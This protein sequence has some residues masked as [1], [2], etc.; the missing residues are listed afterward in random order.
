MFV[1]VA[2]STMNFV[3]PVILFIAVF[4]AAGIDTPSD[5][6]IIGKVFSDK[7]AAQAGLLQG[8]IVRT[9]DGQEISSWRQ[10]VN[11][12]QTNAGKSITINYERNGR[13][14]KTVVTPEFDPQGNRGIIGVVPVINN[15]HPGLFEAAGLAI[16][17]TYVVASAMLSGLGQMITGKAPADVAGP[18]GVA[19]MAGQVAQLGVLPLLQFAAFLSINLGLINLLPVPVLDGGHVV[20]LA[21][22]GIRGKPLNR[23]NL[24]F[25]QM[26]G[27]ALLMLLLVVAT[28]KDITRLR[29]F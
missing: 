11:A 16:K 19:Q 25:I 28:F 4:L 26:I 18:I 27:F 22:E 24:Q 3:L 10:F 14:D 9:V 8:D 1:I 6:P 13:A 23:N 12:I 2:G 7:P 20:T 29:L 15:Y 5:Q 17:Q 21:I